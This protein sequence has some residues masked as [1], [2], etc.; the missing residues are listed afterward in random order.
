[1]AGGYN[2]TAARAEL[3]CPRPCLSFPAY[4]SWLDYVIVEDGRGVR[5]EAEED[6]GKGRVRR[7]RRP[8]GLRNGD[9]CSSVP[10]MP[11]IHTGFLP[12]VRSVK[13]NSKWYTPLRTTPGAKLVRWRNV[14]RMPCSAAIVADLRDPCAV[15]TVALEAQE[16]LA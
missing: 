2:W 3:V 6:W 10:R 1:M 16:R 8:I 15:S 7:A 11:S 12:V 9:Y 4:R 14:L 13:S 5:R